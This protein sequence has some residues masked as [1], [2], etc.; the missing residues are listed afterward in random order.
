MRLPYTV[1]AALLAILAAASPTAALDKMKV[2]VGSRG[3]WDPSIPE[4]GQLGGHFARHGLDV[5]V[6]YTDGSGQTMQA[7]IAGSVA[8][9]AGVGTF[10]AL[11]AFVKGAPIRII[12]SGMTGVDDQY[13]YV[14][15][16]SPIKTVK[17]LA[18]RSVAY[19]TFGASTHAVVMGFQRT[20]DVALK[21]VAAGPPAA[22]LTQVMSGQIDVGWSSAPLN[23]QDIDEGRIRIVARANEVPELRQQTVRLLVANAGMLQANRDL[24]VRFLRA[25]QDTVDWLYDTPAGIEAYAK[26]A[27]VP[28][29]HAIAVRDQFTKR[30]AVEPNQVKGIDLLMADAIRFKFL[31]APLSEAQLAELIHVPLEKK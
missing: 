3:G 23:L 28:L 10:G 4:I 7:A 6:L 27:G 22:C 20:F 2:A 8:V 17:D 1:A 11:A 12:G 5:E 31:S 26:V 15:A 9:G 21:P 19:S 24:F 13:W 18:G 14:R 16:D 30:S 25:Y 29:K